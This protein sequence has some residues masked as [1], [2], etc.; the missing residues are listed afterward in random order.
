MNA[1][2]G[3]LAGT[4]KTIAAAVLSGLMAACATPPRAP[5]AE[6]TRSAVAVNQ[7]YLKGGYQA[8]QRNGQLLYC[9]SEALTGTLMR[10][11]VCVTEAQMKAAEQN[12]QN[13]VDELGKHHG[14]E[15]GTMKCN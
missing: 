15:C 8:V 5:V 1:T 3:Q 9:R 13:V 6:Q 2:S 4:L 12:R 11:T 7:N 10:T 14:P